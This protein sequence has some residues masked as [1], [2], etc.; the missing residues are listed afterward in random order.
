MEQT[1]QTQKVNLI[2]GTLLLAVCALA[3]SWFV[4]DFSDRADADFNEL[5]I[6]ARYGGE[7]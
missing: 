7:W 2:L 4:L 1:L 6:S 3:A 5:N